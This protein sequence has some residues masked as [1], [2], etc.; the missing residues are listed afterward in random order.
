MH[1]RYDAAG[2]FYRSRSSDARRRIWSR[3]DDE[4]IEVLTGVAAGER[5]SAGHYPEGSINDRVQKK[6]LQYSEQQK[7]FSAGQ[8]RP[9]ATEE[10]VALIRAGLWAT[11]V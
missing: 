5:N 11:P 3:S 2:R 7:Q 10:R 9:Y 1:G 6:L 4:G 8:A